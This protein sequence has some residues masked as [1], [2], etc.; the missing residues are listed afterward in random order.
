MYLWRLSEELFW[1]TINVTRYKSIWLSKWDGYRIQRHRIWN[2]LSFI[3]SYYMRSEEHIELLKNMS[4]LE[5]IERT[6]RE[7]LRKRWVIVA[8]YWRWIVCQNEMPFLHRWDTQ[9][10]VWYYKHSIEP[11][12]EDFWYFLKY[13]RTKYPNLKLLHNNEE[14]RSV[15]DRFHYHLFN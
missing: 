13:I 5:K 15:R 7:N 11:T 8:E 1:D 6:K 4:S 12:L 14:S 3:Y 10:V 9:L 2:R